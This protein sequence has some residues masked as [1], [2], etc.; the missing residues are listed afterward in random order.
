MKRGEDPAWIKFYGERETDSSY[1][2]GGCGGEIYRAELFPARYRGNIFLCEPSQNIVH[3]EILQRDGSGYTA[4]RAAGEQQS[5]FLASSDTWFR[6]INLRVGP[7]GALYIV[8]M[9]REIIEDYSAIPRYMQQQYGLL[10]GNDRGRIWRVAPKGSKPFPIK[11]NRY[12][13]ASSVSDRIKSLY[14]SDAKLVD[15]MKDSH[16]GVRVHALRVADQSFKTNPELLNA[17]LDL[18]LLNRYCTVVP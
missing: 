7:D 5:E 10:N 9:Y 6:P 4:R 16:Y 2:S 8:D 12:E 14:E 17:A 15:A 3:R 18:L 11:T 13:P 1:F